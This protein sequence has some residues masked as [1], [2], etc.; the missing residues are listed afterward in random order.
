MRTFLLGFFEPRSPL[1]SYAP[2]EPSSANGKVHAI[3]DPSASLNN[4]NAP[5]YP[6]ENPVCGTAPTPPDPPHLDQDLLD[7]RPENHPDD[8]RHRGATVFHRL[9]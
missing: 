5:G 3:C 1:S 4:R 7:D 2:T 9:D 8:Q 6:L